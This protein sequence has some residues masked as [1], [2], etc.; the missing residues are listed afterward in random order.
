MTI[1]QPASTARVAGHPIHP[2]LVQFP[3]VC[4]IGALATDIA[5]AST[6]NMMWA[7]FSTWLLAAGLILGL[8]A[9]LAGLVDF[10]SNRLVRAQRPAWPLFIGNV[11]VLLLA[12][13]NNFVHSRDAWTSVVPTGLILSALTVV[14]MLVTAWLGGAM[15]YRHRVGVAP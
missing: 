11:I 6:A 13:F 5:F 1:D 12:L 9:A 14:V 2:M 15:V 4:F 7:N 8:L 10:L 3:I